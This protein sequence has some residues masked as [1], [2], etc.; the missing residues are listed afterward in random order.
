MNFS[1]HHQVLCFCSTRR[2]TGRRQTIHRTSPSPITRAHE[3]LGKGNRH[4]ACTTKFVQEHSNTNVTPGVAT[5][6]EP[7]Q[8]PGRGADVDCIMQTVRRRVRFFGGK[9][10]LSAGLGVLCPDKSRRVDH[11]SEG[12]PRTFLH[13]LGLVER[14]AL[15]PYLLGNTQKRYSAY[16]LKTTLHTH[17]TPRVYADCL[18]G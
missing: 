6:H 9:T 12:N 13:S 11:T 15:S 3:A 5:S 7:Q 17:H 4:P 18:G 1:N 14:T 16:A 10:R 8:P 2:A